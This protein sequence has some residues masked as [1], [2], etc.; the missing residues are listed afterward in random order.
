MNDKKI[1]AHMEWITTVAVDF[2]PMDFTLARDDTP[3]DLGALMQEQYQDAKI[4][5]FTVPE[6]VGRNSGA[7][8]FT[9]QA[10]NDKIILPPRRHFG[11]ATSCWTSSTSAT[12]P[13]PTSSSLSSR[14]KRR[15]YVARR[16]RVEPVLKRPGTQ[17]R[18]RS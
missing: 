16:R 8:H 4:T 18:E 17:E 11:A 5:W 9:I 6:M 13:T 7:D 2:D 1:E 3:D 12:K 14:S 10:G 15:A